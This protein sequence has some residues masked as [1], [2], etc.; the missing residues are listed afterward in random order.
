[1]CKSISTTLTEKQLPVRW[2]NR[3]INSELLIGGIPTPQKNMSSSVGMMKFPK[4]GKWKVIKAMFH[5]WLLYPMEYPIKK[6]TII[7]HILWKVIKAMFQ[8]TNQWLL[9]SKVPGFVK[10]SKKSRF[11][12]EPKAQRNPKRCA[13][14]RRIS[15]SQPWGFD[16][17]A[18]V[19]STKTYKNWAAATQIVA[20]RKSC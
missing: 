19:N 15:P 2:L 20:I 7:S 17:L 13:T 4:Y 10:P 12:T 18:V 5:D 1:M 3:I 6:N 16:T 9:I 11:P 14:E 8:T